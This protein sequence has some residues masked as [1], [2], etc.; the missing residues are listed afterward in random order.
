MLTLR[1]IRRRSANA[2]CRRCGR[3]LRAGVLA[4]VLLAAACSSHRPPVLEFPPPRLTSH[5]TQVGVASWYGPGFAGRPTAS[6]EVYDPGKLTA[7]HP[8]LPLGTRVRVTDLD[9]GRSV[10]VRIND[11]GPFVA[12]RI[13][14]LSRAAAERLGMVERGTARVE[15]A[16]ADEDTPAWPVVRYAVQTGAYRSRPDALRLARRVAD[17]GAP[18]YILRSAEP[19]PLYRVR[20]G[21]YATR[22]DAELVAR[23]L[24]DRGHRAMVLEEHSRPGI[25]KPGAGT[26]RS[27]TPG[28]TL[29][30]PGRRGR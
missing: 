21:P 5:G 26:T 4:T 7:A 15:I 24:H 23:I 10:V 18:V 6:G 25:L 12:G 30:P 27:S 22:R 16:L 2:R 28:R 8:T 1:S 20:V 14:D 13:I 11:R 9:S 29:R 19:R 17:L 3:P